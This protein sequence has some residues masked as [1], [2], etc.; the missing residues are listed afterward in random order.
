MGGEK[1]LKFITEQK[2]PLTKRKFYIAWNIGILP[3]RPRKNSWAL[4][5]DKG[6]LLFAILRLG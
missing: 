1:A 3:Q 6:Q 4:E 2:I 5:Q